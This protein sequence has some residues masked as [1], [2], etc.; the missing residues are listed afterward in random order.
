MVVLCLLVSP[1]FGRTQEQF[2]GVDDKWQRYESPHFEL[3][4]RQRDADS[5]A[6]LH[7]LEVLHAVFVDTYH[8]QLRQPLPVTI[9]YFH[10][11]RDFAAYAPESLKKGDDDAELGGFYFASA[12]R[13]VIVV[14]TMYEPRQAR[15][16]IFHEYIHHLTQVSGDRPPMWYGEGLAELFSTLEVE[17]GELIFGRPVPGHILRLREERLMPLAKLFAVKHGPSAFEE[18]L[19]M[20]QFYAESW[21]CC[22]AGISAT[23]R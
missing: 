4:S 6:L 15:Q 21:R 22:T 17:R 11:R 16:T 1:M 18:P 3:F 19:R 23:R 12:D 2:R 5:R 13:A 14:P 7:D 9:Y 8:L 10:R 20:G